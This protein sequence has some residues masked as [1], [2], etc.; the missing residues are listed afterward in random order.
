MTAPIL[1]TK[2]LRDSEAFRANVAHNRALAEK[3]RAKVAE[4]AQGGSA[5]ARDKHTARGKLLPRDRVERLLDPG[6]PFLELR[7]LAPPGLY[8]D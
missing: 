8:G 7:P 4:A 5:S 2:V 3:L 1:D 6:S